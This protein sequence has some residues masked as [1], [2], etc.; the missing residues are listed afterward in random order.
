MVELHMKNRSQDPWGSDRI[1]FLL[2]KYSIRH[3][4]DPT[5]STSLTYKVEPSIS[6]K[7]SN[8]SYLETRFL[9]IKNTKK[10]K[11]KRSIKIIFSN[12]L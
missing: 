5:S 8:C 2:V 1:R 3:Q 11:L 6:V 7:I 9:L 4:F 12:F 10:V